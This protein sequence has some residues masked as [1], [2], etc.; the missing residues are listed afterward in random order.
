MN[1]FGFPKQSKSQKSGRK[2][3]VYFENF[4]TNRLGWIYRPVPQESDFGIDGYIDIVGGVGDVHW[5]IG[6]Q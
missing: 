5:I 4:V 2:G 6:S 3:E 1:D